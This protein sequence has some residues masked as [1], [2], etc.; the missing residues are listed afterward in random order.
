MDAFFR[1][2]TTRKYDNGPIPWD[3]IIF[4][5]KEYKLDDIVLEKFYKII[6]SMDSEYMRWIAKNKSE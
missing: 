5:G 6:R 2:T 1:L 3:V 4:Y